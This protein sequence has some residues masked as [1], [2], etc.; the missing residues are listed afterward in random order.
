MKK[1]HLPAVLIFGAL[2][3][4]MAAT[5]AAQQPAAPAA[6][7]ASVDVVLVDI[8]AVFKEHPYFNQRMKEFQTDAEAA[9]AQIKK[10]RDQLRTMME[11]LGRIK[12][13]TQEYKDFEAQ[14]FEAR[15]KLDTKIQ[16]Q[17]KEF[18][19]R[20][21]KIVHQAYQEIQ[22]IVERFATANNISVVLKFNRDPA[23][24]EN[25]TAIARDLQG[26]VVYY[27]K[28]LDITPHIIKL[29][30]ERAQSAGPAGAGGDSA[31]PRTATR[32]G[33]PH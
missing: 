20:E 11:E 21:A 14:V 32:P 23:D 1:S 15:T 25:P 4:A 10:E 19:Q 30:K 24:P 13:G 28:Y 16:L 29:M 2:V 3:S 12:A 33:L 31:A 6:T 26:P 8:Q 27:A 5:A 7:Q 22:Q 18:V 9:E 17:R